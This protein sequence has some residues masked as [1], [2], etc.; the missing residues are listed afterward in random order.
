E[1]DNLKGGGKSLDADSD[2]GHYLVIGDDGH[3]AG[4]VSL[5]ALPVDRE[6][7]DTTLRGAGSDQYKMGYLPY[8]IVD[9][10]EVVREDFAYWRVDDL[11]ARTAPGPADRATF[12]HL[13][14]LREA[15]TLRDIGYWSHFVG[16]GS[17][18]LHVTVHFNGWL[19]RYP[20][21]QGLHA[22]FESTYVAR[23]ENEGLVRARVRPFTN[24]G[25]TIEQAIASYLTASSAQVLPLYA[26]FAQGAFDERTDAGV[27]FVADR[28]AFGATELRNLIVE[29][30]IGSEDQSVGYPP[31]RVRDIENGTVPLTTHAVHI[32]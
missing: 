2:P 28:L 6:A 29:A 20:H 1:A 8:S 9:G 10:F 18:P 22:R 12:A 7:Y 27:N 21:S 5:D 15:L 30:W 23:Y 4:V 16:D 32:E 26:L 11:G 25:C 13:R 31:K 17:Q 14:A 24:C 3:V 19:P